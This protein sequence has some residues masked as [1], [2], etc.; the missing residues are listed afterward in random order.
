[1]GTVWLVSDFSL[2][3]G[4]KPLRVFT[5]KNLA[6]KF[7]DRYE[8]QEGHQTSL[9]EVDLWGPQLTGRKKEAR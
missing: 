6:T 9:G 5:S 1:M 4:M 8:L 7:A 2:R 3:G